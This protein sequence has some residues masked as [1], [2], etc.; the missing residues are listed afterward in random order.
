MLRN[1][2][3]NARSARNIKEKTRRKF[4]SIQ[5]FPADL[6]KK[7]AFI[8]FFWQRTSVNDRLFVQD[9]E[10]APFRTTAQSVITYEIHLCKNMEYQKNF[11][12]VMDHPITK[13]NDEFL[14]KGKNIMLHHPFS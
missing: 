13:F 9:I 5:K 14:P 1:M 8:S 2:C 4:L 7:V 12:V 3:P 10:L 6:G 11:G